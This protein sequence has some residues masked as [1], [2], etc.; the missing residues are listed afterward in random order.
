M[1]IGKQMADGYRVGQGYQLGQVHEERHD[2]GN[3]VLHEKESSV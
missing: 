3:G 2:D 1:D